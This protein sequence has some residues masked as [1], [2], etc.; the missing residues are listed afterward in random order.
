MEEQKF[1][2]GELIVPNDDIMAAFRYYPETVELFD[3]VEYRLATSAETIWLSKNKGM[4]LVNGGI[5]AY[6]RSQAD[7]VAS[8]YKSIE[9]QNA[10]EKKH[11]LS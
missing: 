8:V 9:K 11:G 1:K 5:E 6:K 3:G 4:V 10:N 7:N 2:R